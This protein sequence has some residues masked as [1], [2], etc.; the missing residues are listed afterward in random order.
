AADEPAV[1]AALA[2]ALALAPVEPAT[3]ADGTEDD[4]AGVQAARNAALPLAPISARTSRRLRIRPI[5]R[6]SSSRS[7]SA[8]S[9]LDV[10]IGTGLV[11]EGLL[12]W[13]TLEG[14]RS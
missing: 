6:S 1:E 2:D 11:I 8:S 12:R 14:S 7:A 5:G 4:P 10:S 3:D 9:A 13:S